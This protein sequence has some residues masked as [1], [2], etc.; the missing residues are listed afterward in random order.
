MLWTNASQAG[1]VSRHWPANQVAIDLAGGT[2][3]AAVAH[4]A[5]GAAIDSGNVFFELNESGRSGTP[6]R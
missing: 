6:N 1:Q 3:L 5:K 4:T 2:E